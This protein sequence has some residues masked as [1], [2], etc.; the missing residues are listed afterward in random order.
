MSSGASG[1]VV[2]DQMSRIDR[3]R[4]PP[5]RR[6]MR[7]HPLE[8]RVDQRRERDL[9][10]GVISE[11]DVAVERADRAS[12][13]D[14]PCRD[15]EI[16][17]GNDDAEQEQRIRLLDA[18]RDLRGSGDA[19]I[20]S[21]RRR[22]RAGE[23]PASHHARHDGQAQPER[24]RRDLRFQAEAAHL[25]ADH[26][27]R[28]ACAGDSRQDLVDTGGERV[29]VDGLVGEPR[30]RFA[31]RAHHVAR[32]LDVHGA[33]FGEAAAQDA[34][35]LGRRALR[36]VESRLVAGDLAKDPQLRIERLRLM[37]QEQARAR[38]ALA[39]RAG[40]DDDRRFLR[41][42]PGHR[43]D[44]VERARPVSDGRDAQRAVHSRRGIGGEADRRLVGE[45]VAAGESATPRS[46]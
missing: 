36:I 10:V 41:V 44:E 12:Q 21:Q 8:Q 26:Q 17:V 1:R 37:V 4:R 3:R 16:R 45:R 5:R 35:D 22:V 13:I 23:E 24:E 34:G 46:P 32:Q 18:L 20:G 28:R 19:Q 31:G 25:D 11:R 40:N 33:R 14:L 30:H 15:A 29:A 6:A 9:R 42:G 38:L 39:G 27:H 43:V 2:R 7:L